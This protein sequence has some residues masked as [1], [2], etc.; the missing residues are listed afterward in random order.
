METPFAK[1]M[2][3][4]SESGKTEV[5][6][7]STVQG[8]APTMGQGRAPL[9]GDIAPKDPADLAYE[10]EK[11]QLKANYENSQGQVEQA[12]MA[13]RQ[14][15]QSGQISM[16]EAEHQLDLLVN[17]VTDNSYLGYGDLDMRQRAAEFGDKAGDAYGMYGMGL[18]PAMMAREQ[19]RLNAEQGVLSD[20]GMEPPVGEGREPLIGGE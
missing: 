5:K 7:F 1:R 20:I 2:K 15:V 11:N 13:L 3:Q 9:M 10:S 6:S 4:L 18:D 19:Q 8:Q 14:Q 12:A 17:K 16:A